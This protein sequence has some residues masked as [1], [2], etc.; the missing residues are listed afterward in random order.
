MIFINERVKVNHASSLEIK[1]E[2]KTA[3]KG[4]IYYANRAPIYN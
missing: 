1:K 4:Q 3:N 2:E